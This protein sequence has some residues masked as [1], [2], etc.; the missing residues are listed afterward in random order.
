M[1]FAVMLSIVRFFIGG[2]LA[3]L[4]VEEAIL[5]GLVGWLLLFGLVIGS[6]K[7]GRLK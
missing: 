3:G 2:G 4:G 7:E 6:L 1:V 5:G